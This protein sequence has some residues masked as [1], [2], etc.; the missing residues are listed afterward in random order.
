MIFLFLS[1]EDGGPSRCTELK[2]ATECTSED[3][4]PKQTTA[5]AGGAHDVG[6]AQCVPNAAMLN[7]LSCYL[8]LQL[9]ALLQH[10]ESMSRCCPSYLSQDGYGDI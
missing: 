8:H 3:G 10:V 9:V 6:Y 1:A 4:G 7:H 5:V 2:T